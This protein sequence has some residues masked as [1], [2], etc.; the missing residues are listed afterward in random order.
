MVEPF[1]RSVEMDYDKMVYENK[2][3]GENMTGGGDMTSEMQSVEMKS[4]EMKSVEMLHDEMVYNKEDDKIMA[5]GYA[6]N[7]LLLNQG[8]PAAYTEHVGGKGKHDKVSDRF[9]HLAVPA[10]LYLS[11]K[12][13]QSK[14]MHGNSEPMRSNSMHTD[15]SVINDDLYEKLLKLAQHDNTNTNKKTIYKKKTTKKKKQHKK[16]MKKKTK[17]RK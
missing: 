4:V 15:T 14:P 5:G 3:W 2:G 8:M 16:S 12:P 11:S 10:G 13:M 9:K 17:K 6:V 7:S 1:N